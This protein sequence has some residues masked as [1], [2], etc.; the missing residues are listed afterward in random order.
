MTTC[1]LVDVCVGLGEEALLCVT[2]GRRW[3]DEEH[4]RRSPTSGTDPAHRISSPG[5]LT[6]QQ[7]TR[8]EPP[9]QTR[10][11]ATLLRPCWGQPVP[12][13]L[14]FRSYTS[15]PGVATT[16]TRTAA[17]Q[18]AKAAAR[19]QPQ[20]AWLICPRPDGYLAVR[21]YYTRCHMEFQ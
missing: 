7:R 9:N 3:H 6:N 18:H 13:P 20:Q 21:P 19:Q 14:H 8:D 2:S 15:W 5:A 4:G 12:R 17:A 1:L 11:R 10:G 16:V